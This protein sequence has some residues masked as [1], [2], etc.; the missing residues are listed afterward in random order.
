MPLF[1]FDLDGTLIDSSRDLAISTNAMLQH[2][3]RPEIDEQTVNSYVGDGAAKLVRRALGDGAT[4]DEIEAAYK[5]FIR[6]YRDHSL[7]N[8]HLYDGIED[9]L[10]ALQQSGSTLAV[11]TNK[12]VK[13]SRDILNGLHVGGYFAQVYGGD[14]FS[15]KKPDPVGIET[16]MKETSFQPEATTMIGDTNVDTKTARAAGVRA[17]GVTWGFKPATLN[18]PPVDILARD[19]RHLPELLLEEER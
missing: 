16:I 6:Y 19:V 11:L 14:S 1:I 4:E 9:V 7:E 12:P 2:M 8:T 5:F 15:A 3:N 18:D 17:C 10:H 13:I